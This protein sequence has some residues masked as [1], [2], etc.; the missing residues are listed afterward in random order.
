MTIWGK[1]IRKRTKVS[2]AIA[3]TIV[4]A[5][6]L[7]SFGPRVAAQAG[8]STPAVPSVNGIEL[9]ASISA[10]RILVGQNISVTMSIS[11]ALPAVNNVS[12]SN[13]WQFQ[14]V[15]VALWGGCNIEY[16]IEVAILRGNY[17]VQGVQSVA[18]T[19]LQYVCF[20]EVNINRVIFQPNSDQANLT[21]IGPAPR[22][23]QTL[24][25]YSQTLSFSAGGSWNLTGLAQQQAISIPIMGSSS[26]P[27]QFTPF[28]PGVYTVAVEDEWGQVLILH[29][30]VGSSGAG[31][32][33]TT[34]STEL[35]TSQT[36][37]SQPSSTATVSSTGTASSTATSG[38]VFGPPLIY[39]AM[40][41]LLI[42][43]LAVGIVL[44]RRR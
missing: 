36:A 1:D 38:S 8:P 7:S 12:T 35:M 5:M 14:G 30:S 10:T 11:N 43:S 15:R 26:D 17:T 3:L 21:G 22:V 33:A 4:G 25:P 20:G 39:E 40:S 37:I 34:T 9:A 23:N 2:L 18:N 29:F 42:V 13:D 32:P 19:T 6:S 31:G 16:P 41:V 44:W 27:V 24:G 28:V